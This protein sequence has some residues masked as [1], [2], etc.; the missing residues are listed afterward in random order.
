M[1]RRTLLTG[2]TAAIMLG[3]PSLVLAR[4][5]LSAVSM[6]RLATC[7]PDLQ[8]LILRVASVRPLLVVSGYRGRAAQEA[9]FAAGN[10]QLHWP[11]SNHNRS[12]S[13]AVDVMPLPLDW[14]DAIA[15]H[16]FGRYVKGVAFAMNLPIR[17]GGNWINLYDPAHFELAP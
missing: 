15:A 8:R 16:E 3:L 4:N 17:W 2:L 1:K 13:R 14:D 6:E 11:D 12:P 10:S 9:A 7:H 5:G